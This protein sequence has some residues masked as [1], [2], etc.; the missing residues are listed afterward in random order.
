MFW[1]VY[2]LASILLS[3]LATKF[4]KKNSYEIFFIMIVVLITPAQIEV[5][6]GDYAP[7]LFT[8]VYNVIFQQEFSIRT[9][10]PLVLSLPVCMF[11]LFIKSLIKRKF[12]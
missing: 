3:F 7:S 1:V 2:I 11:I 6:E 5:S 9:L 4:L 10:R 12:F 8:F